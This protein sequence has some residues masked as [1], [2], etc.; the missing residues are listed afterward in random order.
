MHMIARRRHKLTAGW[1]S[2]ASMTLLLSACAMTPHPFTTAEF[3]A[4]GEA[5]RAAMFAQSQPLTRPLTLSDAVARVLHDNL[6]ARAKMM[7]EAVAMGQLEL[8]RFTLLPNL[9]A[10]GGYLGR[11]DHATVSS[12]NAVTLQP[13]LSDPYL[14]ARSRPQSRRPD[15][16]VERA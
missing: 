16:V 2:A 1:A 14:L 4:K 3:A 15:D 10:S 6:D 8:D 12:R 9:V 13:A 5:D 11:S 7:E